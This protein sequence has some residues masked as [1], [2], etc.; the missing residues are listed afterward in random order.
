MS[1]ENDF[2]A[3]CEAAANEANA[4]AE[5]ASEQPWAAKVIQA[6]RKHTCVGPEHD[7]DD[8]ESRQDAL[9]KAWDDA[10]F[11]AH[12]RTS[13][14]DLATRVLALVKMVRERDEQIKEMRDDA[15]EAASYRDWR[16]D[17]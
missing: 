14:P 2:L 13:N 9:I 5:K 16:S 8:A 3:E 7:S 17:Q 1:D 4:I 15:R 12:A 11:I 10:E 6:G